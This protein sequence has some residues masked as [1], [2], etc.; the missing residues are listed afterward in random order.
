MASIL[1][2]LEVL[3]PFDRGRPECEVAQ[4]P[5]PAAFGFLLDLLHDGL[6][7]EL[8]EV[9]DDR[10]DVMSLTRPGDQ[11]HVVAHDHPGMNDQPL[12]CNA[13]VQGVAD[14]VG[15]FLS[16]EDIDPVH[17]G[18]GEE[19]GAF[20]VGQAVAVAGHEVKLGSADGHSPVFRTR[21]TRS[22]FVH[23][24]NCNVG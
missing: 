20:L 23:P 19:V 21:T 22:S 8:L 16:G 15:V 11:V 13:M 12:V 9:A 5:L 10:T 24:G 17:H 2:E 3:H 1:P 14:Q 18:E 6:C 7:R 4:H